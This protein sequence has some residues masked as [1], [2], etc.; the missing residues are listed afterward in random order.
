[1]QENFW[2][3]KQ[4]SYNL[5]GDS[6][7]SSTITF[8][9]SL[10][11]NIFIKAQQKKKNGKQIG[12]FLLNTTLIYGN[13]S[14]LSTG[15]VVNIKKK[16]NVAQALR[17]SSQ[18]IWGTHNGGYNGVFGY[19][20]RAHRIVMYDNKWSILQKCR[21]LPCVNNSLPL[22]ILALKRRK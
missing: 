10:Q 7:R 19:K 20:H 22:I 18:P 14:I 16:N 4:I 6:G 21:S 12:Y 15:T 11:S 8:V 17:K 1:M 13:R 9:W 2:L 5:V 3:I